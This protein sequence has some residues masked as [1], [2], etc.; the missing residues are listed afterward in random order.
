MSKYKVIAYRS[1]TGGC[2]KARLRDPIKYLKKNYPDLFDIEIKSSIKRSDY[3]LLENEEALSKVLDKKVDLIILQR[4]AIPGMIEFVKDAQANG[5]KVIYEFDDYFDKIQLNSTAHNFYIKNKET[6]PI[7]HKL[8]KQSD[9]VT[10]STTQLQEAYNAKYVLPNSID[11]D[12]FNNI[13]RKENGEK[14][15][16]GWMGSSTHYDDIAQISSALVQ[17]VNKYPNVYLA[18]GG[19]NLKKA[20]QIIESPK[21]TFPK[22]VT[23]NGKIYPTIK[24]IS[25]L[26]PLFSKYITIENDKYVL[27][28]LDIDNDVLQKEFPKVDLNEFIMIRKRSSLH[29]KQFV[30]LDERHLLEQIDP[31]K[32]IDI[33]WVANA[34]ELGK[35]F[36]TFDIGLAPL[37]DNDFNLS[38]SQI[39]WLQYSSLSVPTIASNVGP[40]QEIEDGVTGLKVKAKGSQHD[41]WVKALEKLIFDKE[42]RIQLGKNAY[43]YVKEKY[44]MDKN[45][46]L[47]KNTWIEVIE[48]K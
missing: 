8:I 26:K 21:G 3:L 33:P 39:K 14:V 44:D 19:W 7:I 20:H 35:V 12:D 9:A 10:V 41:R 42:Y 11:F 30:E 29:G 43:K 18:L 16:I 46:E 47:W 15:V 40:Y 25:I 22:E 31:N 32:V 48:G 28:N 1:D 45:C 17:V 6:L 23:V 4:S 2:E 34:D 27:Q 37:Q 13:D 38:K 5:V 36:N 24:N